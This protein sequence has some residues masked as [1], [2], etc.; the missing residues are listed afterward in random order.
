MNNKDNTQTDLISV[1][2]PRSMFSDAI[3]SVRTNLQFSA[4]DKEL[5]MILVTSSEPGNGKSFISANLAVAYAQDGK[6][7]L[8]I[9][10]DLRRGRQ[11]DIFD[12]MNPS[13]AG[14]SN[15]ILNYK[16]DIKLSRYIT[17]TPVNNI[18]LLPTGP[19]PPNPI[20]LLSSKSNEEVLKS[21]KDYYDIIILDCPPILG[22]AD[23]TI[24]TKFSDANLL[25]VESGVTKMEFAE[26]AK[27]AFE[28][29]NSQVTGVIIN[30]ASL[31]G[32]GYHGYYA[33]SYYND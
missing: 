2:N 12:V 25:V 20:E 22:M 29:A 31:R 18:D 24:M 10:C 9:D 27:K 17:K 19:I 14:Y 3:K 5:K 23:T 28:N 32:S 33:S 8:V 7:V 6:K 13:N 11:H 1:I 4:V 26:K 30:K 21:I 16:E 15:L